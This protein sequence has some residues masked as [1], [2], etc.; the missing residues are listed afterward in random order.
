MRWGC[1]RGSVKR[2]KKRASGWHVFGQNQLSRIRLFNNV[3][4]SFDMANRLYIVPLNLL[5]RFT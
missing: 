2:I 1:L 3:G 4:I 5:A